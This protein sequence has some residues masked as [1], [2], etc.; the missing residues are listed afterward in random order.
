MLNLIDNTASTAQSI[1]AI[2]GWHTVNVNDLRAFA[3]DF[4][5]NY[6]EESFQKLT[7]DLADL[8]SEQQES[9]MKIIQANNFLMEN[10]QSILFKY[11]SFDQMEK[12]MLIALEN[13][14]KAFL[15]LASLQEKHDKVKSENPASYEKEKQALLSGINEAKIAAEAASRADQMHQKELRE[16]FKELKHA[17]MEILRQ[18]LVDINKAQIDYYTAT[19]DL[20]TRRQSKLL[21]WK[22]SPFD[23]CDYEL[24]IA[25]SVG[26][27]SPVASPRPVSATRTRRLV[28]ANDSGSGDPAVA[29]IN[30]NAT[31][32]AQS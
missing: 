3:Y 32:P 5:D 28:N 26:A 12:D 15:R 20:L 29:I 9:D 16:N 27:L 1:R 14:K 11:K 6:R 18:A 21:Q 7:S 24:K 31:N 4:D 10:L 8:H 25:N 22:E 23:E 30:N 19:T 17:R 13:K 2:S